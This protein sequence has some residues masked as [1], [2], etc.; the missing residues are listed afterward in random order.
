MNYYVLIEPDYVNIRAEI[1]IKTI[2]AY[3]QQRR[4]NVVMLNGLNKIP[5]KCKVVIVLCASEVW[6]KNAVDTL[7]RKDIHPIVWGANLDTQTKCVSSVSPSFIQIFYGLTKRVITPATKKVAFLGF[8][9]DSA[10]DRLKLKGFNLAIENGGVLSEVFN[11]DGNLTQCVQSF[12]ARKSEFDGVVCA[13]DTVAVL[14]CSK[15]IDD[16]LPISGYGK[17]EISKRSRRNFITADVNYKEIGRLLAKANSFVNVEDGCS[18]KVSVPC[19]DMPADV[20][21]GANNVSVEPSVKKIDFYGDACVAELDRLETMLLY[22]DETDVNIINGVK[23][24]KTIE[25]LS[26]DCALSVNAT[27]YRLAKMQKNARVE[28]RAELIRLI[29]KYGLKF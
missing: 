3:A 25:K 23:E 20:L 2:K 9:R 14:L 17:L 13:N 29:D 11:N 6:A 5:A 1:I 10:P 4:R 8:N 26:E 24:G 12:L 22:F 27:K 21:Y 15:E 19:E 28:N 7:L 18:I 16:D